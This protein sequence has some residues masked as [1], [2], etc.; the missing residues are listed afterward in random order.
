[1]TAQFGERL[2]YDGKAMSMCM[3]PLGDYIFRV[4]SQGIRDLQAEMACKL[5]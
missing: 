3:H 2:H 5:A 4:D 1:M